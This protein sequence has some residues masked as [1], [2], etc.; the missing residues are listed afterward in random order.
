M[1]KVGK[2]ILCTGRG[3][4]AMLGTFSAETLYGLSGSRV[5]AAWYSNPTEW[6]PGNVTRVVGDGTFDVVTDEGGLRVLVSPY[7]YTV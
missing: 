4:F 5:S 2:L 6:F 3:T 7:L 1:F